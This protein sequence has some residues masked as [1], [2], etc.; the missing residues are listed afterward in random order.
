[1]FS[2]WLSEDFQFYFYLYLII[3]VIYEG[4]SSSPLPSYEALK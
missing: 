3:R 2:R 4:L 1:M